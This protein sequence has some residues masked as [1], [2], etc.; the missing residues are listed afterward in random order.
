[1]DLR[2]GGRHQNEFSKA[3]HKTTA[4]FPKLTATSSKQYNRSGENSSHSQES[5]DG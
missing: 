2:S 3:C 1:M 4:D 5:D